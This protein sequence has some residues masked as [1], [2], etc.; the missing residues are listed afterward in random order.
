MIY[1]ILTGVREIFGGTISSAAAI[2]GGLSLTSVLAFFITI[3]KIVHDYKKAGKTKEET[4]QAIKKA[5][6]EEAQKKD[7]EIKAL[8]EQFNKDI[9]KI[10]DILLLE[11]KRADVP[12]ETVYQVKD[13]CS[14]LLQDELKTQLAEE[15]TAAKE[16]E[17]EK[18]K[19]KQEK[20]QANLNAISE[21][22]EETAK[23]LV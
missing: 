14:D 11:L 20:V 13:L 10:G 6:Q 4:N 21:L 9:Q 1:S 12:L 17:E 19:I 16:Q 7:A 22:E 3:I 2:L 23:D 15:I 5:V 18:N 8:K